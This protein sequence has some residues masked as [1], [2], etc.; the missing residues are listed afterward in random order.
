MIQKTP[1]N[2]L[3]EQGD[4]AQQEIERLSAMLDAV[5]ENPQAAATDY[6]Q[7]VSTDT[8]S[9]TIGATENASK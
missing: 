9:T 3:R 2:I 8:Q 6:G 1:V 4:R 7:E 5:K